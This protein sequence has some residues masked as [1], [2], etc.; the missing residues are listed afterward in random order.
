MATEKKGRK[1]LKVGNNYENMNEECIY[2][3][4]EDDVQTLIQEDS[5]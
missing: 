4:I 5:D 2:H 1:K 3:E